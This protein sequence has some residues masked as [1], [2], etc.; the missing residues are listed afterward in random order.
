MTRTVQRTRQ[1]SFAHYVSVSTTMRLSTHAT[2][3]ERYAAAAVTTAMTTA[4]AIQARA[5]Q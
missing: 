1:Q 4:A 5:K 3:Y 2:L